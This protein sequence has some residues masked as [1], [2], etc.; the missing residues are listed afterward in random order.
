M[1]TPKKKAAKKAA[2]KKEPAKKPAAKK[3]GTESPK[4]KTPAAD[5]TPAPV[6]KPAAA[7]APAKASKKKIDPR[8]TKELV[9]AVY[10][11][12]KDAEATG[13]TDKLR[14][15]TLGYRDA[16]NQLTE[17]QIIQVDQGKNTVQLRV[18]NLKERAYD[19]KLLTIDRE[20][21][22]SFL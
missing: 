10:K 17:C 12:V 8:I 19:K 22:Q 7:S 6:T 13:E 4:G 9:G 5:E 1:A 16:E 15:W 11:A 14:D 20:T 3:K 21:A 2:P 18:Y